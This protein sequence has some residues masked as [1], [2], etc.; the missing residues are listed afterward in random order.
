MTQKTPGQL[1][2]D[3]AEALREPGRRRIE[4]LAALEAV[5]AELRPLVREARRMEVPIR[6]ITE[7]TAVAPN[8][9]RAWAKPDAPE[10]G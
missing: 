4:L 7:L 9:V 3:A 5:D 10:A 8:T 2:D 6:R 1:R